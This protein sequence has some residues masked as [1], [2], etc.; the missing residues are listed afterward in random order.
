[1]SSRMIAFGFVLLD[2]ATTLLSLLQCSATLLIV[3]ACC[4]SSVF[5]AISS[6]IVRSLLWP[7]YFWDASDVK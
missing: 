4:A 5:L 1:M 6:S 7:T 3:V 2:A